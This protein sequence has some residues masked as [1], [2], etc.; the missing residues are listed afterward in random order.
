MCK[1]TA[2]IFLLKFKKRESK[3]KTWWRPDHFY[4]NITSDLALKR[5]SKNYFKKAMMIAEAK[6]IHNVTIIMWKC[7]ENCIF[8]EKKK[9]SRKSRLYRWVLMVLYYIAFSMTGVHRQLRLW[10]KE[11]N[12]EGFI[13]L[14]FKCNFGQT[15][16]TCWKYVK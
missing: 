11:R 14:C 6:I 9:K 1:C 8:G 12:W 7:F 3:R 15:L 2:S 13:V 5:F 10:I 16:K 4:H